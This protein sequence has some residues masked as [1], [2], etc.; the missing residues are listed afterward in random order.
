MS[1]CR[2]PY[3]IY[4]NINGTVVFDI[5]GDI[6]DEVVNIFLYKLYNFRNDEFVERTELGRKALDEWNNEIEQPIKKHQTFEDMYEEPTERYC[7]VTESLEQSLK[8]MQLMRQGK[9][10]KKTIREVLE[11][12]DNE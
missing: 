8:E 4:P 3:Y 10:P 9:L 6:P 11:E 1:Y 2:Q 5:F 7:T 12:L